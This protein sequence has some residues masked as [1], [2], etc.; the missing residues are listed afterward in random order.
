MQY[1]TTLFGL[2]PKEVIADVIRRGSSTAF[3]CEITWLTRTDEE[4]RFSSEVWHR[5]Y[6]LYTWCETAMF[7]WPAAGQFPCSSSAV[8]T[9]RDW[10]ITR[11]AS[12]GKA[13]QVGCEITI[14]HPEHDICART[15][16]KALQKLLAPGRLIV[17]PTDAG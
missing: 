12:P 9:L 6:D 2:H 15:V 7:D 10:P 5:E 16:S 11:W 4:I 1:K 17:D 14:E 13:G 8:V 3:K